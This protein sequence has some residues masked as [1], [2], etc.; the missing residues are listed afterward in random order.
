MSMFWYSSTL[1]EVFFEISNEN[2]EIVE[3]GKHALLADF[4]QTLENYTIKKEKIIKYINIYYYM[5]NEIHKD[6]KLSKIYTFSFYNCCNA[7]K[8]CTNKRVYKWRFYL[9]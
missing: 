4:M 2:G 3:A 6:E 9:K 1:L 8:F 5:K 7:N